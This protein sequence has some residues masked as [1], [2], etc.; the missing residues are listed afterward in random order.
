MAGVSLDPQQHLVNESRTNCTTRYGAK[1]SIN[2]EGLYRHIVSV[3]IPYGNIIFACFQT[4]KQV[5]LV[6]RVSIGVQP[7]PYPPPAQEWPSSDATDLAAE[8]RDSDPDYGIVT[9]RNQDWE[10]SAPM[11][12]SWSGEH[13]K[14]DDYAQL[15]VHSAGPSY[16]IHGHQSQPHLSAPHT[17]HGSHPHQ[18]THSEHYRNASAPQLTSNHH[19]ISH[20][21]HLTHSSSLPLSQSD[22]ANGF[23]RFEM[24]SFPAASRSP[25][26][27]NV[28]IPPP[29]SDQYPRE[30][31]YPHTGTYALED[32]SPPSATYAK[33]HTRVL[34][35]DGGGEE[36]GGA[37]AH[38]ASGNG[39]G[40]SSRPMIRPPGDIER[41][42]ICGTTESPEWRR[43]EAGIKDLCNA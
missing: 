31:G 2:S 37:N 23:Q 34:S 38:S 20:P 43:S 33:P 14:S 32:D 18:Q 24:N 22:P 10:Y 25:Y 39:G 27:H 19:Q 21:G 9:P 6:Q 42:R 11:E 1:H 36:H 13:A 7:S 12:G 3:F 15:P 30:P 4:V 41:C 35:E 29:G 16:D 17:H 28:S 40:S 8:T 5:E 26:D